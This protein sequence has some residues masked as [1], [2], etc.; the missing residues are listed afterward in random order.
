MLVKYICLGVPYQQLNKVQVIAGVWIIM[1]A[2]CM[3]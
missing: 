2:D 3:I 1:Q